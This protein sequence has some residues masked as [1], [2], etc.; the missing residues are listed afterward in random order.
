MS[1]GD[2]D[3]CDEYDYS[4]SLLF[5]S[6]NNLGKAGKTASC[7]DEK[8]TTPPI[9][10]FETEIEELRKPLK[11]ENV[12]KD[13][14]QRL[15][16]IEKHM[17]SMAQCRGKN[18]VKLREA[19]ALNNLLL[20]LQMII[21]SYLRKIDE[22]TDENVINLIVF[23]LG[24]LRDLACGDAIN[25]S[26]IGDFSFHGEDVDC[27]SGLELIVY[28][29]QRY[30]NLCWKNIMMIPEQCNDQ[31]F[32][33]DDDVI[34]LAHGRLELK[35]L[36]SAAGVIRNITHSTR[37]NC[38][39]LHRFGVTDLFIWRLR[40][41]TNTSKR[42]NAN[43]SIPN[44]LLPDSSKPWREASFRIASSLINMAEKSNDCAS[45]CADDDELIYILLES[46]G[47]VA[48]YKDQ[49]VSRFP[50]LHLGLMA[51]L[52]E[53]MKRPG[54]NIMLEDLI[55]TLLHREMLRK[56]SAQDREERRKAARKK[57]DKK[58]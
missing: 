20:L 5:S 14:I 48:I 36:T 28:F 52:N 34:T 39:K 49:S 51:I 46:W 17:G 58:V 12:N 29:I 30:H 15:N 47:G 22:E 27:Q 3:V 19:G 6:K 25:R 21:K 54:L 23:A 57:Q 55:K 32:Q 35:I 1:D 44:Q 38:E 53:R 43:G 10:T 56:K 26:I 13:L 7:A 11:A 37:S 4:S 8:N 31:H 2:I 33:N 18:G 9:D 41:G 24:A 42:I 40:H 50:V 45:K 16:I